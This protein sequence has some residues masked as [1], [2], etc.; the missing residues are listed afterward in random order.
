MPE[1][2]DE[3]L[4][5]DLQQ[6][7][8]EAMTSLFNRYHGPIYRYFIKLSYDNMLG[9]ELTQQLFIKVYEKRETFS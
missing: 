7:Q 3:R 9:Q 2:S 8:L 4:M 1:L 5:D 6:G